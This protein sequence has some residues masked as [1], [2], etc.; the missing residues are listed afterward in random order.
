M[1][2]TNNEKQTELCIQSKLLQI[3]RLKSN[4]RQRNTSIRLQQ[5]PIWQAGRWTGMHVSWI[6]LNNNHLRQV[7]SVIMTI[8]FV[9]YGFLYVVSLKQPSVSHGFWASKILWS[10]PWPV[11]F[12]RR[13]QSR[14]H[15]TPNVWFLGSRYEPIMYLTWLLRYWASKAS[16]FL[17]SQP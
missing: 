12:M 4:K 8:S 5:R 1:K 2:K 7:T 6:S 16:K 14:D 10:R 9:I 3:R 13:H 17:G 15:W 11:G